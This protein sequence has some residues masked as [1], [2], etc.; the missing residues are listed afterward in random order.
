MYIMGNKILVIANS[1]KKKR[2]SMN[3]LQRLD[4]IQ[5]LIQINQLKKNH[6]QPGYLNTDYIFDIRDYYDIEVVFK[7]LSEINTK[8][9][10]EEFFYGFFYSNTRICFK[11]IRGLGK[12]T[13]KT[14]L[15]MS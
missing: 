9:S 6:G 5:I 12:G 3:K 10:I 8:T 13:N 11:I 4:L 7:N 15:V 14:S 1:K 2:H